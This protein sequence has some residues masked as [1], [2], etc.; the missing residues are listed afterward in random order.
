MALNATI[1]RW[2]DL[3]K[4]GNT[5]LAWQ[6]LWEKAGER[7]GTTTD[8]AAELGA[9]LG[10]TDRV[11]RRVLENLER[12]DAIVLL[13]RNLAGTGRLRGELLIF[14]RKPETVARSQPPG[15]DP[16]P[17]LPLLPDVIEG[18]I[19]RA[20]P[21]VSA[22]IR[23]AMM[24][25]KPPDAGPAEPSEDPP[26][27]GFAIDRAPA[28]LAMMAPK[29]PDAPIVSKESRILSTP[30][31]QGSVK[32]NVSDNGGPPTGLNAPAGAARE[33][34]RGT[35]PDAQALAAELTRRRAAIASTTDPLA[36]GEAL[37]GALADERR[38]MMDPRIGQKQKAG[39]SRQIA[40]AGG[41]SETS[42]LCRNGADLY[43]RCDIQEQEGIDEMLKRVNR[44]RRLPPGDPDRIDNAGGWLQ[45]E[46]R[47]IAERHGWQ[48][49]R[50]KPKGS[51]QRD[52]AE[53]RTAPDGGS[54]R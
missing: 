34:S 25:P 52:S 36:L 26:A 53:C 10:A 3:E 24:A 16:G 47:K 30:R 51:P 6:L 18:E 45:S 48:W 38:R 37:P 20:H 1:L 35:V 2:P 23:R 39:L 8:S 49:G 9:A 41:Q 19:V 12:L 28:E 50:K 40:A 44:R 14:V 13:N 22:P 29:P 17:Q 31:N 21:A 42:W 5:K 15:I 43:L 27:Q 7:E 4:S 54:E 46:L 32:V 33:S 11:G